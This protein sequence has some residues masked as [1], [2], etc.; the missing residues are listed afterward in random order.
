MH[1]FFTKG[2]LTLFSNMAI[3]AIG[4][5]IFLFVCASLMA[6]TSCITL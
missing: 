1:C 2:D 3:G 5:D 4:V 6:W